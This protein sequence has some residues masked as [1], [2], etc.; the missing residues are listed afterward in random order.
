QQ[1]RTH[2]I[3]HKF[4]SEH[5]PATT[6]ALSRSKVRIS[7]VGQAKTKT[8]NLQFKK[9]T[10]DAEKGVRFV[11]FDCMER[12]GLFLILNAIWVIL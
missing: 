2:P 3:N 12:G 11:G 10:A 4:Y 6:P 8:Y 5:T 7:V 1:N 9:M